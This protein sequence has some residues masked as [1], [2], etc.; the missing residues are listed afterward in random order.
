MVADEATSVDAMAEDEPYERG[1]PDDGA[2]AE[3]VDFLLAYRRGEL[4]V[5]DTPKQPSALQYGGDISRFITHD[6]EFVRGDCEW[7]EQYGY[8]RG[9]HPSA[10]R[11][12]AFRRLGLPS[13]AFDS[14]AMR[15][16]VRLGAAIFRDTRAGADKVHCLLD[17]I[18]ESDFYSSARDSGVGLLTRAVASDDADAFPEAVAFPHQVS[19]CTHAAVDRDNGILHI[20]DL[21]K[22][23]RYRLNPF[24]AR[25]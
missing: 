4:R 1:R 5:S 8:L 24:C 12:H 11:V 15:R 23:W 20:A 10:A 22:D 17:L 2:I 21:D 14:P 19:L 16:I 7:F 18:G 25:C 13:A 6:D 3:A 9:P